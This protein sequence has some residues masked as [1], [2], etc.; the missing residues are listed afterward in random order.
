MKTKSGLFSRTGIIEIAC[1]KEYSTATKPKVDSPMIK[2]GNRCRTVCLNFT[3]ECSTLLVNP[4]I[5]FTTVSSRCL[6]CFSIITAVYQAGGVA[7]RR[8]SERNPALLRLTHGA[9]NIKSPVLK[10][11]EGSLN[12]RKIPYDEKTVPCACLSP[13][14]LGSMSDQ[15]L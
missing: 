6:I 5:S 7:A 12:Q 3:V 15:C 4:P 11:R 8:Q 1:S 13:F 9:A 10:L 14:P 2:N